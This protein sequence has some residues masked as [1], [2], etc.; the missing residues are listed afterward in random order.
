MLL[1][2]YLVSVIWI[3]L[4]SI[5]IVYAINEIILVISALK[6][7]KKEDVS[8]VLT[9]YP[10][11]T[12]QLPVY[13][14]GNVV[15]RLL[16]AVV[17]LDYPTNKLEIQILDDST[18]S[19][20]III[21]QYLKDTDLNSKSFVV[22]R[23][24]SRKGFKAGALEEG[25]NCTKGDLVAIFDADF[26]PNKDFLIHA[27]PYFENN[28]KLGAVQTRW[29]FIND[30]MSW[31]TRAQAMMLNTHF[32]VEQLGRNRLGTYINFNGT[33]GIWR[34]EC[35]IDS[36]GWQSDT[37]TEDLDLS[38]RA[39][40]KGW[41]IAYKPQII[42]P[43]ELPVTIEAYKH[44][45]FRWT[46]GT[47]ECA[48]KNIRKLWL[49]DNSSLKEKVFGTAHL[50][51]ILAYFFSIVLLFFAP[52]IAYIYSEGLIP[53]KL[54]LPVEVL[55]AFGLLV[56]PT[57]F[58]IGSNFY[59]KNRLRQTILFP[60]DFL[61]FIMITSSILPYL[62]KGVIEGFRGKQ[63]EFIRTPKLSSFEKKGLIRGE[64]FSLPSWSEILFLLLGIV[65]LITGVYTF[66]VWILV[67]GILIIGGFVMN[68][69]YS[70]TIF[71]VKS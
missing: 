28:S 71:G 35:L 6:A 19:T 66:N 67:N 70:R 65:M 4:C 24:Q 51:N 62:L 56:I 32:S 53:K 3:S 44:Q 57:V 45:Q 1:F 40:M 21:D 68:T 33:A 8:H 37:L 18:D 38:Y 16:D 34:K 11:V 60:V 39:Q 13:N 27:I 64:V 49:N 17:A 63:T 23:R 61:T 20:P 59:S 22:L 7:R 55:S 9:E 48:R 15:K 54:I 58:F 36:G 26:V 2:G 47:A 42:T 46:K 50:F 43:S 52:I 10:F 41:K 31:I 30:E 29:G 12:I 69:F 14:E 5:F 25:L